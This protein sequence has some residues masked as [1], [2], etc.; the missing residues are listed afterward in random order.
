MH[1][2][3]TRN[4][5]RGGRRVVVLELV[6]AVHSLWLLR[7]VHKAAERGLKLLATRAVSHASQARAIPVDLARLRVECAFLSGFL[8]ERLRRPARDGSTM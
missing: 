8:L 4:Q 6:N 7:R 1:A 2:K 5:G 3:K